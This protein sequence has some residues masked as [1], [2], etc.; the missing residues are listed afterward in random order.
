MGEILCTRPE[1]SEPPPRPSDRTKSAF[2]MRAT[3]H[4]DIVGKV[5]ITAPVDRPV[6]ICQSSRCIQDAFLSYGLYSDSR[7]SFSFISSSQ[8]NNKLYRMGCIK[9][10]PR[11]SEYLNQLCYVRK[12]MHPFNMDVYVCI[13]RIPILAHRQRT[14][15]GSAYGRSHRNYFEAI[16]HILGLL[17]L[18]GIQLA[19]KMDI[20]GLELNWLDFICSLIYRNYS[21]RRNLFLVL[22]QEALRGPSSVQ[23][24][25]YAR[26]ETSF[27]CY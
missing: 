19:R 13:P 20:H 26:I 3:T 7:N 12:D 23:N 11:G 17:P 18:A 15:V 14:H 1:P 8:I 10:W 2:P 4:P 16:S 27:R 22:I 21:K 6:H 24:R 25:G 5:G 9:V